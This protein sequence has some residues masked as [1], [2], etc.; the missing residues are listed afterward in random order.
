MPRHPLFRRLRRTAPAGAFDLQ[1]IADPHR[2][3]QDGSADSAATSATAA[4]RDDAA[5]LAHLPAAKPAA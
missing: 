5:S 1:P 2:D 3:P 4:H